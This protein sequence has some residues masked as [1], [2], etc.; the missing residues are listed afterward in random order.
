MQNGCSAAHMQRHT[1]AMHHICWSCN[2]LHPLQSLITQFYICL[3][4]FYN[5]S[6]CEAEHSGSDSPEVSALKTQ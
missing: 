2:A 3:Q 6:T 1:D 5:M 4:Q